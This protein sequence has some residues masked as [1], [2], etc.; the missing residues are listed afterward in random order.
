MG[1]LVTVEVSIM[2]LYEYKCIHCGY[3]M[4]KLVLTYKITLATQ[5]TLA[6]CSKCG[7][8]MIRKMGNI[9]TF[10]IKGDR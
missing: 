9:A 8:L 3:V 10:R 1:Q 2:P 5:T 7:G 4:E 6:L